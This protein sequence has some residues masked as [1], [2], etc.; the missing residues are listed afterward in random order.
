MFL[1]NA[2][3][4]L[5]IIFPPSISNHTP[6]INFTSILKIVGQKISSLQFLMNKTISM[7]ETIHLLRSHRV[8]PLSVNQWTSRDFAPPIRLEKHFPLYSESCL[9]Q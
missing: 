8:F 7:G 2:E 4:G 9:D 5:A 6:W 3:T 1:H